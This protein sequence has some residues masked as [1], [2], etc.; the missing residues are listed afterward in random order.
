MTS[1]FAFTL[2]FFAAALLLSVISHWAALRVNGL[3]QV[4]GP[5]SRA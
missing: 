4:Q 3:A 1:L 5:E 2:G